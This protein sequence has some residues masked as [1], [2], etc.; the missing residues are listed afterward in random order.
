MKNEEI[1]PYP[2]LHKVSASESVHL[3]LVEIHG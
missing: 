2:L 3:F 1:K